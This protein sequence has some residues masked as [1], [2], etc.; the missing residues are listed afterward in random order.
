MKLYNIK[1]PSG[2]TLTKVVVNN[3]LTS[4]AVYNYKATIKHS[5]CHLQQ[6]TQKNWSNITFGPS[7]AD[8]V[9]GHSKVYFFGKNALKTLRMDCKF[10]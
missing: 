10:L 3:S 7:F 4:R 2:A 5:C 1:I 8:N 9:T 6:P